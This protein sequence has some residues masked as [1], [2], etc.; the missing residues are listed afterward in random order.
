MDR[1]EPD[2]AARAHTRSF[3]GEKLER[4]RIGVVRHTTYGLGGVEIEI[5]GDGRVEITKQPWGDKERI[6]RQRLKLDP[7]EVAGLIEAFV[8]QAFTEMDVGT[9]VGVPDELFFTLRLTNARGEK[10]ELGKF[11]RTEHA[12]FDALVNAVWQAVASHL[13]SKDRKRLRM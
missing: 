9:P 1:H 7:A 6:E 12:G 8:A 2:E 5:R 10:R 11:V 13:H 3:L 4:A